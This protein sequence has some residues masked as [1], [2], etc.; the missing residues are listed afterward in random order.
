MSD[1]ASALRMPPFVPMKVLVVCGDA[2]ELRTFEQ[3]ADHLG[4][5]VT[6]VADLGE[7]MTVA[8]SLQPELAFVDV[9][10]GDGGGLPLV[11]H[12]QTASEGIAIYA[13]APSPKLDMALEGLTL[14]ATGMVTLPTSGDAILRA[15]GEVREKLGTLRHREFLEA[16]LAHTRTALEAMRHLVKL[17]ARGAIPELMRAVADAV[18][19]V[20]QARAVSVYQP[21]GTTL[22]RVAS[23]GN[24]TAPEIAVEPD[25]ERFG[26]KEGRETFTLGSG[27]IVVEGGDPAYRPAV[28]DLTSFA[29]SLVVLAGRAAGAAARAAEPTRFEPVA[30][31]RE[32]L[33]REVEDAGRHSRKVSAICV[34]LSDP[35]GAVRRPLKLK[36][37]FRAVARTGDVLGRDEGD[38]EVWLLLPN[39]GALRAQLLRRKIGFGAVGTATF[40]Q[41]AGSV[42]DLM[43]LSRKRAEA[44]LRSPVRMLDLGR[45]SLRAIVD[46]LLACP[47]LD[48]GAGSSY[49]LDLAVPAAISL[50]HHAC[51]EAS[52]GGAISVLV[53]G[54]HGVGFASAVRAACS[55]MPA[56][57]TGAAP[58]HDIVEVDLRGSD[59]DGVDAIVIAAEHGTWTCCGVLERDRF[60]A[61][62]AADAA[63]ADL[64]ARKLV[65][66]AAAEALERGEVPA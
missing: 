31:F 47:L 46:G 36:E 23:S 66:G 6:G 53:S 12:L 63:L 29:S 10:L 11:H 30:R 16:Q 32:M 62:H 50:V 58:V 65:E 64:V 21:E 2:E 44:S 19:A 33:A 61:V 54:P 25:L 35:L 4:D 13:M 55:A 20:G 3:T 17:A 8:A 59:G 43:K 39:T 15:I 14:G 22:G 49:P 26:S 56:A 27:A 41:D 18:V 7:A 60:K 57:S 24:S 28:A 37:A 52:R 42:D 9:T 48:A 45:K 1:M 34:V 40:P 38:D 5:R 51:I